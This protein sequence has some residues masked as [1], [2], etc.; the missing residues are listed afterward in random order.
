MQLWYSNATK[1]DTTGQALATR[2]PPSRSRARKWLPGLYLLCAMAGTLIPGAMAQTDSLFP[3]QPRFLDVDEAFRFY[4]SLDSAQQISIHWSIAPGYYLYD[5]KFEFQVMSPE[6]VEFS[7]KADIP[8]GL[9]HHDEFFGDVE[10]HYDELRTIVTLPATYE[11]P[12]EL[13]VGFQGCAEAGLCY[14]PQ[15]QRLE[16]FP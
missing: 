3:T 2:P 13:I 9:A 11:Q 14:P 10:V 4:S 5:D 12:F 6:G 8:T 1:P 7:V 16:I 15:Q